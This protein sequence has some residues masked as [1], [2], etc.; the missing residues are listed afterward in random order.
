MSVR[1]RRIDTATTR[2]L[3]NVASSTGGRGRV[4]ESDLYAAHDKVIPMSPGTAARGKYSS[5]NATPAA[6]D[7]ALRIRYMSCSTPSRRLRCRI[8]CRELDY[9]ARD[10]G[11]AVRC[12]GPGRRGFG[13]RPSEQSGRAPRVISAPQLSA[14]GDSRLEDDDGGLGR[15]QCR[16]GVHVLVDLEPSSP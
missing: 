11:R 1:E 6:T 15:P 13:I 4:D 16:V 5:K 10:L 12:D 7:N 8:V 14:V 2:A 3:A 9:P